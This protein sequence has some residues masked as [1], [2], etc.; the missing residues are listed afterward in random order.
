MTEYLETKRMIT[1]NLI[2]G[3]ALGLTFAA[4]FAFRAFT[5]EFNGEFFQSAAA[6]GHPYW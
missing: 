2:I 4:P 5:P 1:N 6:D 3:T